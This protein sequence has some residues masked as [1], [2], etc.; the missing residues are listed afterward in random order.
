MLTSEDWSKGT[1]TP[2]VVKGLV[3]FTDGSKMKVRNRAAVYGQSVGRKLSFSLVR[4]ATVFVAEM[5]SILACVY[6]IQFQS[7]LRKYV[8]AVIGGFESSSGRQN[9]SIGPTVPKGVE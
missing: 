3:W 4:Y 8:S 7:R 6:E 9:V 5:Y 1:G 2:P